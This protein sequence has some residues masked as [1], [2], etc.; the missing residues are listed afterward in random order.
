MTILEWSLRENKDESA[1]RIAGALGQFW[2]V[3]NHFKEG[4][5]WLR[6]VTQKGVNNR[7]QAKAL[8]WASILARHQ[9]DYGGG[10]KL[11]KE[12]L[13]L[14]RMLEDREGMARALN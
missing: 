7:A 8:Y 14:C 10:K 11:S 4:R 13:E 1:L 3:H 6:R 5:G 2:W 12:S 9:G